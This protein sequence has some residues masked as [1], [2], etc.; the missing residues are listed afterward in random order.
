M[1][2]SGTTLGIRTSHSPANGSGANGVIGS[3]CLLSLIW[4]GLNGFL[5]LSGCVGLGLLEKWVRLDLS[6]F[7]FKWAEIGF[8]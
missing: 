5:P 6:N 7:G 8:N 1:D 2:G 3:G 4:M